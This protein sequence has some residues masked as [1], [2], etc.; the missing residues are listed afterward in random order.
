MNGEI[1]DEEDEWVGIRIID[2]NGVE[3]KVAVE[4]AGDIRGH[5]Q[6]G[7]PDD[8]SK[9]TSEGNEHVEQ[10]RKFAQYYVYL[11]RGHDTVPPEIHPE[12]INAVRAAI[13]S[14]DEQAFKDLFGDLY[15]QLRSHHG[16]ADRVIDLPAD[17]ARPDDVL[18]RQHVYLGLDLLA[19]NYS[20]QA[21]Q[22]AAQHGLDLSGEA[23]NESATPAED[24]D[25]WQAVAHEVVDRAATDGADLTEGLYIDAISSLYMAYIDTTSHERI[26]EPEED[27]YSREPDTLIELPPMDT[28]TIAEFQE[29]ITHNLACQIRDCFVRMGLQPPEP[30]QIL[31]FGRF[32]AAE[33]YRKLELFPDYTDPDTQNTFI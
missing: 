15:R 33:Q 29:Y 11:K 8:P 7:Y 25:S 3:H 28:G 19:T 22:L 13:A 9:R 10:A 17:V 14:L 6:N 5:S 24:V 23:L 27:P 31:G 20:E 16:D 4:T 2:N 30:F 21:T 12:R 1:I 18:Y 26:G 32:E